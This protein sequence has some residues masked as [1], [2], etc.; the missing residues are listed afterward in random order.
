MCTKWQVSLIFR[1]VRGRNYRHIYI[2]QVN[3]GILE[4]PH[5]L[6]TSRGLD[7]KINDEKLVLQT[8]YSE[9]PYPIASRSLSTLNFEGHLF[10]GPNRMKCEWVDI[11][12]VMWT[13]LCVY[14]QSGVGSMLF[15]LKIRHLA[16]CDCIC[17]RVWG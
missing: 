17:L 4:I 15:N 16:K 12:E 5:R 1:L 2:I 10:T 6:H 7:N 3:L 14:L 9:Y 11:V 8:C 13:D